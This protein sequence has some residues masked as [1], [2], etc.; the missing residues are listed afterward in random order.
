MYEEDLKIK[1]SVSI[2]QYFEWIFFFIQLFRIRKIIIYLDFSY[3]RLFDFSKVIGKMWHWVFPIN[4]I[5]FG[6]IGD[7][8]EKYKD[9][10]GEGL[11]NQ[12]L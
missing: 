2:G 9:L 4:I 11:Y 7:G 3:C 8:P 12:A 5:C 1:I 10:I 6:I